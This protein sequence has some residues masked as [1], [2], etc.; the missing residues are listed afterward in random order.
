MRRRPQSR[1]NVGSEESMIFV[2][3]V[4]RVGCPIEEGS[5]RIARSRIPECKSLFRAVGFLGWVS[6]DCSQTVVIAYRIE[7]GR[8]T[9]RETG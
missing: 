5:Q 8:E 2:L 6:Y 9:L 1:N 4:L 3:E 7:C